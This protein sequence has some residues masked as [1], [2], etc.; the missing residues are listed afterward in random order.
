MRDTTRR[1]RNAGEFEFVE[2]VVVLGAGT[3]TLI[4][5]DENTG[6]VVEKNSDHLA[7]TVVLRLISES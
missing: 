7:G 6:L 2:Q 5:L 4:E 1:G 3:F